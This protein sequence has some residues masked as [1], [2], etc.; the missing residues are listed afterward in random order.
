MRDPA[1]LILDEAGSALDPSTEAAIAETLKRIAQ[2]R[3]VISVTHRLDSIAHADLIVVM[4]R[5]RIV[6]TGTHA[7]L[8]AASGVYARMR[9]RQHSEPRE[10]LT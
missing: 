2:Q 9:E 5:G 7:A 3:T 8:L 1:I 10:L 4:R 6:E